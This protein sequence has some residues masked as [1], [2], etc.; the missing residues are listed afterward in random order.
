MQGQEYLRCEHVD[1]DTVSLEHVIESRVYTLVMSVRTFEGSTCILKME[2]CG[3]IIPD[4]ERK[5]FDF[6]G[7]PEFDTEAWKYW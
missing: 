4:S 6:F 7:W 5:G 1:Y 3:M 2:A